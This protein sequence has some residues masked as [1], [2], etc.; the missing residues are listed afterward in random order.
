[1][2]LEFSGEPLADDQGRHVESLRRLNEA[3]LS[4]ADGLEMDAV[5][6]KVLDAARSLTGA[7][8][9]VMTTL[10]EAGNLEDF[11][12]S[13]MTGEE[14]Q[15]FWAMPGGM[16]FFRYLEAIPGPLRLA[17]FA[18][19]A[20]MVGLP[21]F[22]SPAPMSSFLMAPVLHRGNRVGNIHM[23]KS[24][25]GQEFSQEDEETL[26]MFASQAGMVIANARRY[27]EERRARAALETLVD[28]SPVGVA[29][30]D[31]R[32][33]APVSINREAGRIVDRLKEA[34][35]TPE[36]LLETLVC[37]RA[38][39][40]EVSLKDWP[41]AEAMATGETVRAEEI[42]LSAPGGQRVTALLNATPIR[43]EGGELEFFV[44][45]LQDMA[46]LEE[47]ERLRAEFLGMVSHELRTPLTSIRGAATTMQEAAQDLDAAELRQFLRIIVDQADNM[48]ELIDDLLDVARIKTGTLP[49]NPE[50]ADVGRLVD[51]ARNTFLTG[52][53][54][55]RLEIELAEGLPMVMADRRRVVQV[56]GN[57]LSN[58]ANHSPE[59]SAI[60]VGA[61][62]EGGYVTIFVA[63]EGRG[64]PTEDLPHLFGKFSRGE[65][66]DKRGDTGL[67]LAICKGIVEA[68]GGR[69]WA[70]SD[71][72]RLGARFVFTIPAVEE[73]NGEARA[74]AA[75]NQP[76]V[77]RAPG[78]GILVVDDDPMTLGYVRRTLSDAGYDPMV[79]GDVEE[80]LA[81]LTERRPGLVL[82]DMMLPGWDGIELMGHILDAADVPVVFLSG[83]GQAATVSR[84]FET[85]ASD[86]IVKPFTSTELVARV[87][88]VLGRRGSQT[89]AESLEP[90]AAGDLTI[91]YFARQVTVA[92]HPVRMTAKEYELLRL[93][94]VNA[95]RVVTHDQLLR[96]LWGVGNRGNLPALRTLL[97]RLRRKLGENANHPKYIF[98][99]SRVGYRMV[100]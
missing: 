39:G 72:P 92:G 28:T 69:I 63:D 62:L 26:V 45:T 82:L 90:Y 47:T 93:L 5:L 27:R 100:K 6:Q 77:E 65:A 43:G 38:D 64:I 50:P 34:G 12:A 95:G 94:S 23:A 89:P 54:R 61:E 87:R 99:E 84:A 88:A 80:A 56:I 4:I 22:T 49:V 9:G 48:R 41:L 16:E 46:P 32:T 44:V 81:L 17:D 57:L 91:D 25:P 24:R 67:G 55:N 11:L 73:G 98:S 58:A 18:E 51:R 36:Q 10:D 19:N 21:E 83:Y 35:Q 33:G 71:G 60:R 40:R 52:G 79:T 15:Q 86:Y 3:S 85:G 53:G 1:M 37:R 96:R 75:R 13:G 29:V 42:V 20:G 8:Y 70:E 78:E 30:F 2:T 7:R 74:P 68:H 31:A 59:S 66:G 97:R 76:G 14:A